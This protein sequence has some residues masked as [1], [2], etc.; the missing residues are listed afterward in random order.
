MPSIAF[1]QVYENRKIPTQELRGK[2]VSSQSN[3]T[4]QPYL[5]P[6]AQVLSGILLVEEL[7]QRV[8]TDVVRQQL[9]KRILPQLQTAR[10]DVAGAGM[11]MSFG[12]VR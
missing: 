4:V 10:G 5:P 12:G 3:K 8:P 7:L 2:I 1:N 9:L 6:E 11:G